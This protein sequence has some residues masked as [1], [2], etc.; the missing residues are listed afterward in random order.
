MKWT[1]ACA[2]CAA[3]ASL[4]ESQVHCCR[5][6]PDWWDEGVSLTGLEVLQ[7]GVNERVF[8]DGLSL[9]SDRIVIRNL[10]LLHRTRCR[11]QAQRKKRQAG[12]LLHEEGCARNVEI[13]RTS[14][15]G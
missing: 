6:S 5:R 9:G 1:S 8:V 10:H 7:A 13:V 12:L 14:L 3:S 11:M 2:A 4:N 15:F